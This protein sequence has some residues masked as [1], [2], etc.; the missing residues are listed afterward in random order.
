MRLDPLW[1]E[2]H[3]RLGSAYRQAG[4]LENAAESLET[5][6]RLDPVN[7]AAMFDLG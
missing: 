1:A 7:F 2:G 4:Q 5:A 6:V 3:Q